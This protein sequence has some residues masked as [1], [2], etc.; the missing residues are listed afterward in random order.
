MIFDYAHRF[1]LVLGLLKYFIK[2]YY[3]HNLDSSNAKRSDLVI[4]KYLYNIAASYNLKST[5]LRHKSAPPRMHII[6][7]ILYFFYFKL[8]FFI[9]SR[10]NIIFTVKK[11]LLVLWYIKTVLLVVKIAFFRTNRITARISNIQI[12]QILDDFLLSF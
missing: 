10:W 12:F 1:C 2:V 3:R 4:R 7:L 6:H 9:S 11:C 5:I 8:N